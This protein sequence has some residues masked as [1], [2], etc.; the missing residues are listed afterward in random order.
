MEAAR[1]DA[2][3]WEA[4]ACA[5]AVEL[6]RQSDRA[7]PGA[8]GQRAGPTDGPLAPA[9]ADA[10]ALQL[11]RMQE[12]TNGCHQLAV[13]LRR[14]AATDARP[15][16]CASPAAG[17]VSSGSGEDGDG[18]GGGGGVT[19]RRDLRAELEAARA[20]GSELSEAL[21]ERELVCARLTARLAQS[22][23]HCQQ[24]KQHLL[25]LPAPARL[26]LPQAPPADAPAAVAAGRGGEADSAGLP[27]W[28]RVNTGNQSDV[29]STGKDSEGAAA[30]SCQPQGPCGRGVGS[31]MQRW[32]EGGAA[33]SEWSVGVAEEEGWGFGGGSFE[34]RCADAEALVCQLHAKGVHLEASLLHTLARLHRLESQGEGG[35]GHPAAAKGLEEAA[36]ALEGSLQL[37]EALCTRLVLQA[38]RLMQAPVRERLLR[39]EAAAARRQAVAQEA[40]VGRLQR[41][42]AATTRAQQPADP[43]PA[44]AASGGVETGAQEEAAAAAQAVAA[45]EEEERDLLLGRL[46]RAREQSVSFEWRG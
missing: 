7:E 30:G 42:L 1:R 37:C 18:G 33:S 24:L 12:A 21:V 23:R 16:R 31:V 8:A 22:D 28:I 39:G 20:R 11:R 32:E 40:E 14:A 5:L 45:A 44:A 41:R 27:P 15:L 29:G 9:L 43:P 36:S 26:C 38:A 2:A 35:G 10:L 17:G 46:A 6:D 19:G 4:R 34:Q 3:G 13:G 25:R